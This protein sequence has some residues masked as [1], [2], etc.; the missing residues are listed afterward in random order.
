[1]KIPWCFVWM[2]HKLN[3]SLNTVPNRNRCRVKRREGLRSSS[4]RNVE[5]SVRC[6]RFRDVSEWCNRDLVVETRRLERRESQHLSSPVLSITAMHPDRQRRRASR[7]KTG[8]QAKCQTH[9]QPSFFRGNSAFIVEP[10][11]NYNLQISNNCRVL[12]ADRNQNLIRPQTQ[13]DFK[14]LQL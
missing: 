5:P 12:K 8:R 11:L 14:V 2:S 1:M 10:K 7:P 9:K 4:Y 3:W 13:L 6:S